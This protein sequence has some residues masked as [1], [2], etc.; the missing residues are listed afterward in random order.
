[1]LLEGTGWY[2]LI[3]SFACSLALTN[4][5]HVLSFPFAW[6]QIPALQTLLQNPA[7]TVQIWSQ[8]TFLDFLVARYVLNDSLSKGMPCKH[9]VIL[10]FVVG[11]AGLISHLITKTI[12]SRK[13]SESKSESE[14]A[15]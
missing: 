3:H 14:A 13:K 12:F 2:S 8:I 9:S 10:C 1:M 5:A 7:T 4:H 11:P 15:T 6:L